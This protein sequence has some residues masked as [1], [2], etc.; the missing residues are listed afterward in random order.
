M[1]LV[2]IVGWFVL[3]LT[4]IYI[5]VGLSAQ[6][7][8]NYKIKSTQNLSLLMMLLYFWVFFFWGLYGLLKSPVDWYIVWPNFLGMLVLTI[9]L[10]QFWV[11]RKIPR[12]IKRAKQEWEAVIDSLVPVIC[13]L[14]SDGCILRANRTIER[15]NIGQ[16]NEVNGR[17]IHDLFHPHCQDVKCS[18]N[19]SIVKAIKEAMQGRS[20]R[21]EIEISHR[22]RLLSIHV[23]RISTQKVGDKK[24]LEHLVV[25]TAE[26]IPR[27][28]FLSG[29]GKKA[30][31]VN[32][33]Y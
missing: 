1:K 25:F 27:F 6:I 10:F 19:A 33:T 15:W 32:I 30:E 28:E 31:E 5:C 29:A 26:E 17:T 9:I 11:Y 20:V 4:I 13:L 18:F 8:N 16:V 12:Q 24:H 21:C 22:Q 2:D 7:H 3:I 23:R 14:D